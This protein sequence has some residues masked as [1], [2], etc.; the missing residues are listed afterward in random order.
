[1][2]HILTDRKATQSRG[3]LKRIEN[4]NI[5]NFTFIQ[6]ITLIHFRSRVFPFFQQLY[7]MVEVQ[8][9]LLSHRI[10][11]RNPPQAHPCF[12]HALHYTPTKC[13]RLARTW[14]IQILYQ[15]VQGPPF[16]PKHIAH[17]GGAIHLISPKIKPRN[18]P[19]LLPLD[20]PCFGH[21][22]TLTFPLQISEG[23]DFCKKTSE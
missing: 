23:A 4:G 19:S 8:S 14:K 5:F 17:G 13:S 6:H 18:H 16:R 9:T 22:R 1:M 21:P 20:P 15:L 12:K 2:S 3:P 11:L 7:H 10:K